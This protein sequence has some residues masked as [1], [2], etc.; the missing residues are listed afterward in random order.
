MSTELKK[1]YQVDILAAQAG[2]YIS[3]PSEAK[4]AYT[5]IGKC[6]YPP[7]YSLLQRNT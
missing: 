1:R 4:F 5:A 2:G 6:S 3:I 7:W